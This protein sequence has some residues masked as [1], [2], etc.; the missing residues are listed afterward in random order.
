MS[1]LEMFLTLPDVSDI[2]K[3]VFVSKRLGKFTVKA[4]TADEHGEYMKRSKG[5][6]KKDDT[7]FDSSKFNLL[8]VAGQ[9]VKPDFSNAELLKN[10][11]C[12]GN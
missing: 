2:Q 7:D 12:K 3:E 5:K 6:I 8:I 10:R 4:M 1:D 9:T 11:L